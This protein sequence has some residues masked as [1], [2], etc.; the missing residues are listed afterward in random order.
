MARTMEMTQFQKDLGLLGAVL[1]M[2]AVTASGG[3]LG[4]TMTEPS[5]D[6]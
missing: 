6:L 1:V 2:F 4:P 3:E 5:F